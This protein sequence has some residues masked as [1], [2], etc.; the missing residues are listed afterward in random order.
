[1]FSLRDF[2]MRATLL[3]S[4]SASA[5]M[6]SLTDTRTTLLVC[7]AGLIVLGGC[8]IGVGRRNVAAPAE[9]AAKGGARF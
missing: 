2:L 9:L 5:W 3:V 1:V 7:A 8:T 4:V 6:V